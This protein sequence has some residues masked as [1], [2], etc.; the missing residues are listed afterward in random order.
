MSE[1]RLRL[2]WLAAA[3]GA[4][5]TLAGAGAIPMAAPSA[6][7]VPAVAL[8]AASPARPGTAAG[9]R[10]GCSAA[11][12]HGDRRLG[13][14]RLAT[15]GELG[16][17]LRGYRRLGG[18]PARAFLVRFWDRTAR[19]GKGGWRPAAHPGPPAAGWRQRRIEVRLVPGRWLDRFGPPAGRVL[20]PY[21]TPFA[22]RAL[23]PASLAG[24][25]ALACDYYAYQV[26]RAFRVDARRAARWF[27]QPGGGLRYHLSGR[28]VP[29]SPAGITVNWL[30]THGYLRPLA[31]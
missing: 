18:L 1:R 22:R 23:P 13:P 29:H 26:T 2:R 15:S 17:I 28:L 6:A 3:L 31:P 27:R 19:S 14:E 9:T 16:R 4:A 11:F 12:F 24:R 25:P 10:A 21:G 5:A 30:V 7:A 8:A 20:S